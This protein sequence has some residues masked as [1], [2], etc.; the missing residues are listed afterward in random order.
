MKN[1]KWRMKGV[2]IMNRR[3]DIYEYRVSFVT[4]NIYLIFMIFYIFGRMY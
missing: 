1:G 3:T 4:E 2:L